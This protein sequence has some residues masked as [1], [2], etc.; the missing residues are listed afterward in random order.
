MAL[1]IIL[2]GYATRDN[3]K[4]DVDMVTESLNSTIF[5]YTTET[6]LMIK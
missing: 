1:F 4:M 6:G 3:L 5:R 2:M